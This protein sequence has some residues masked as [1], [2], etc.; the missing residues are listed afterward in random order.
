MVSG[1]EIQ[2]STAVDTDQD[3]QTFESKESNPK[4]YE[5][6]IENCKLKMLKKLIYDEE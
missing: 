1:Y 5:Y 6:M 2:E 3:I 4:L